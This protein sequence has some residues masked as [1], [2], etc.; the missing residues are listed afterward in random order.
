MTLPS[1]PMMQEEDIK[2]ISSY[3]SPTDTVLE[4]G[5]G[6]STLYFSSK[7]KEYYSIE[8]DVTWSNLLYRHLPN[9]V[10]YFFIPPDSSLTEPWTKYNEIYSY[11]NHVD[12]L[13]IKFFDK[14]F[15]DGRGRGFCAIKI[16]D[17]LHKDSLVFIHDFW[18]RECRGYFE[19]FKYYDIVDYTT[20]RE[21]LVILKK[22]NI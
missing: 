1:T 21:G 9:N 2:L 14:V 12:T 3:L 10:K 8:H 17:Y 6:G 15:I 18:T 20:T 7:V 16:L 11:V 19:V 13:G 5:S 22:K 4:W